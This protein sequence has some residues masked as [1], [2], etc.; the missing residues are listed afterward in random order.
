MDNFGYN[1]IFN[2]KN[3]IDVIKINSDYCSRCRDKLFNCNEL[4]KYRFIKPRK[5]NKDGYKI[6]NGNKV[7]IYKIPI[8]N[9]IFDGMKEWLFSFEINDIIRIFFENNL[10]IDN[11]GNIKYE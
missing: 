7:N 8:I 9:T 2:Q 10:T 3:S 5:L 6:I 4:Y 11:N 1:L